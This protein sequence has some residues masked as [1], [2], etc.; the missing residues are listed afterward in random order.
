MLRM[1]SAPAA[2]R[3]LAPVDSLDAQ[4]HGPPSK[5]IAQ[6]VIVAAGLAQGTTNI[7]GLGKPHSNGADV[8]AALLTAAARGAFL[9]FFPRGEF[10]VGGVPPSQ[11][12]RPSPRLH[13]G[14]S[15]TLARL[16]LACAA[17]ATA[18]GTIT[19]LIPSGS[20]ARRSSPAL[21]ACLRAAGVPLDTG[22][23]PRSVPARTPPNRLVLEQPGSSQSQ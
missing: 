14:E 21:V 6:R 5:S 13:L 17:L 7:A 20:L 9:G 12:G 18:E 22:G 3:G 11:A 16:S 2:A 15:G 10:A 19:E 4:F 23:W 8:E 1:R